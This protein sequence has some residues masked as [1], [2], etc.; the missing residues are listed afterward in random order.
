MNN[1]SQHIISFGLIGA[2][3]FCAIPC[4]SQSKEIINREEIIGEYASVSESEW[5]QILKLEADG[6]ALL[7]TISWM[8]GDPDT[9]KETKQYFQWAYHPPNIS[10]TSNDTEIV[11]TLD[12]SISLQKHFQLDGISFK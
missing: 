10:L 7:R 3:L 9:E 5:H 11:L 1:L 2:A 4:S 12:S 8:P 6:K